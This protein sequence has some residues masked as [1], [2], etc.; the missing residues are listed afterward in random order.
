MRKCLTLIGFL[1]FSLF[2]YLNF[3]ESNTYNSYVR[4]I[5]YNFIWI[6]NKNRTLEVN[7]SNEELELQELKNS[8]E[9]LKKLTDI[10]TVLAE[11][12]VINASVIS[13]SLVGWFNT[14]VIDKGSILGIEEGDCVTNN[15]ALIGT[16]IEVMPNT[17]VVR[18][19]TNNQNKVSA[20][21]IGSET[22]YGL[23]Y[24]YKNGYLTMKGLKNTN[25]EIGSKV[26]TTGMSYIY[27]AGIYIGEVNN[28]TYD[29]FELTPNVLIKTPVD[30][31]NILYFSVLKRWLFHF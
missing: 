6:F 9:E 11:F 10:K 3:S 30:F 29:K 13:R 8:I 17:S 26:V 25:I 19:I 15:E 7:Y 21:I 31:N 16:V 4:N 5:Y 24:E 2:L 18:L 1:I 27:P 20:K 22:I 12:E 28:V 14:L 23:I